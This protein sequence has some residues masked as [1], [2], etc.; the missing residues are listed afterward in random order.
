[1]NTIAKTLY[2]TAAGTLTGAALLSMLALPVASYAAPP[3]FHDGIDYFGQCQVTNTQQRMD[4]S[5]PIYNQWGAV[6][7]HVDNTLQGKH[8]LKA[9]DAG[10]AY[11]DNLTGA[12]LLKVPEKDLNG[13][14]D[15]ESMGAAPVVMA[16]YDPQ[17]SVGRIWIDRAIRVNGQVLVEQMPFAP[18]D[19]IIL[20]YGYDK[21][22]P[23]WQFVPGNAGNPTVS[24]P[25]AF[26][27]AGVNGFYAAVGMVLRKFSAQRGLIATMDVT[28]HVSTQSSGNLFVKHT[29][30]TVTYDAKPIWT[31]V[32]PSGEVPGGFTTG[33]KLPL[34]NPVSG[35]P[36]T[37][38]SLSQAKQQA[39]LWSDT[40][41]EGG[42]SSMT[43][44]GQDWAAL[45]IPAGVEYIHQGA[46]PI[47]LDTSSWPVYTYSQSQ[48]GFSLF[49]MAVF[50]VALGAVTGG[51]A[52]AALTNSAIAG[53][54]VAYATTSAMTAAGLPMAFGSAAGGALAGAGFSA[55]A[56]L[57]YDTGF[58]GIAGTPNAG[59]A[60]GVKSQV[61]ALAGNGNS[62]TG[63]AAVSQYN[64]AAYIAA[65]D[66][67]N[68]TAGTS[69][70]AQASNPNVSGGSNGVIGALTNATTSDQL[71]AP[72]SLGSQART[73][74]KGAD[75]VTPDTPDSITRQYTNG[76]SSSIYGALP[77]AP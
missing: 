57:L 55:A 67:A 76:Q 28:P 33:Y 2:R 45:T 37:A 10:I 74:M 16:F 22:N 8:S 14:I 25:Y 12:I 49:T 64:L 63:S 58:L 15:F 32:L 4:D 19:G 20:S 9:M 52:A 44:K 23:F 18:E 72:G 53:S 35:T 60:Y 26:V 46:D 17:T 73:T 42:V 65:L 48:S 29:K 68:V 6:A 24:D 56:S 70:T 75:N 41:T 47:G 36:M 30:E 1:M 34:C 43:Y 39:Q 27:N 38:G 3:A 13:R 40:T 11:V 50:A 61:G 77:P 62:K 69:T 59:A 54:S 66:S 51:L 71:T 5:T 7:H 21:N 31:L